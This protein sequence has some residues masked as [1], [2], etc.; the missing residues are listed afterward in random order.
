MPLTIVQGNVLDVTEDYI[1]QQ[2]CCTALR[3]SGLSSAIA[4]QFG[5][6]PYKERRP[7]S[8]KSNW[9]CLEDRPEP[10]T[11]LVSD[12]IVCLFAQYCHGKPGQLQDPANTGIKDSAAMRLVYFVRCLEAVSAYPD[13]HGKSVAIPYGIGCGL[14]GGDWVTYERYLQ[15]WSHKHPEIRVVLYKYAA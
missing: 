10:G 6:N 9:A 11:I 15:K 5:V 3:A 8:G 1:L 13:I 7:Y 2:N 12:R 14:A 4:K